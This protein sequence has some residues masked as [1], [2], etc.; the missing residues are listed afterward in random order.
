MNYNK[1]NETPCLNRFLVSLIGNFGNASIKNIDNNNWAAAWF[2]QIL[3][4]VWKLKCIELLLKTDTLAD[5]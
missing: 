1:S 5:A 2:H 3:K 4:N